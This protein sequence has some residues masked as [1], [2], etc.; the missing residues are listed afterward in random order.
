M[1]IVAGAG[2]LNRLTGAGGGGGLSGGSSHTGAA[3][4]VGEGLTTQAG[5][6][7][8]DLD[9]LDAV[10]TTYN[11][12]FMARNFSGNMLCVMATN[13]QPVRRSRE[14][15]QLPVAAAGYS[16]QALGASAYSVS[17]VSTS[18]GLLADIYRSTAT[19]F[20]EAVPYLGTFVLNN[21]TSANTTVLETRT[22]A[23]GLAGALPGNATAPGGSGG[24]IKAR[25]VRAAG[26]LRMPSAAAPGSR[27]LR[28]WYVRVRDMASQALTI[29]LGNVTLRNGVEFP[30]V[31]CTDTLTEVTLPPGYVPAVVMLRSQRTDVAGEFAVSLLDPAAGGAETRVDGS[32]W[33]QAV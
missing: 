16:A 4:S 17:Q 25:Y 33:F 8:T 27:T 32:M 10:G 5:N 2:G 12:C 15:L 29:T 24:R 6:E 3:S 20:Y 13:E 30:S 11:P 7:N 21:I 26:F 31:S 14:L 22:S 19:A 23:L 1:R 18:A 28:T 9:Q